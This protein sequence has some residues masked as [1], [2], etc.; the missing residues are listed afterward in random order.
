MIRL[1]F[2]TYRRLAALSALFIA[3]FTVSLRAQNPPFEDYLGL[4]PEPVTGVSFGS[5]TTIAKSPSDGSIWVGTQDEGILRIGRKGNRIVY[6]ESSNH[7]LSDNIKE[8]CFVSASQLYI[9]Y[10]DGRMTSYTPTAGFSHKSV[11]DSPV[12]HI[13]AAGKPGNLICTTFNGEI[14]EIDPV[15]VD[16]LLASLQEPVSAISSGSD[17]KL[18]VAGETSRIVKKLDDSGLVPCSSA[19]PH[20]PVSLLADE[21]GN[22]WAASSQGLYLWSGNAWH[23]YSTVDGLPSNRVRAVI[24]GDTN[25]ILAATA[26]GI[27]GLFV[28]ESNVSNAKLYHPG[29]SFFCA[30]E[31]TDPEP[32]YYF[33]GNNGIAVVS[34]KSAGELLPWNDNEDTASEKSSSS[35]RLLWIIP[36]LLL[37]AAL[38][39][40]IGRRTGSK[41]EEVIGHPKGVV[42]STLQ[43][44]DAHSASVEEIKLPVQEKVQVEAKV[45][46]QAEDQVKDQGRKQEPSHEPEH[47]HKPA[48]THA[49]THTSTAHTKPSAPPSK[50]VIFKAIERLKKGDAPK[51][52]LKV[53]D[54]VEESYTD[55]QFT[56]DSIASKLMLTRVHVN[57]KLQQ[58]IGVS[59]SAILKAR[60][61]TAA[62]ELLLEGGYMLP[63]VAQLAGFSSAS[64]LSA[65]FKDYYGVSPSDFVSKANR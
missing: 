21:T 64:Y 40:F 25:E 26:N 10:S 55:P 56:V 52:S 1:G 8:L 23:R 30:L 24:S 27:A 19:I 18:Y 53:W 36:I 33:G 37:T 47:E 54:L 61:M 45:Q 15:G 44:T 12:S 51:F 32:L 35:S 48:S 7:L 13:L 20:T 46:V 16:N 29:D 28:S 4:D 39:F 14:H 6:S 41:K 50:E 9:L 5:V 59:P 34:S 65:S 31:T 38:F 11:V 57:R 17:G 3:L 49:Q 42:P 43:H 62:S 2:E 63:Q 60:R 58:E 22:I